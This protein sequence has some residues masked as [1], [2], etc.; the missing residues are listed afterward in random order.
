MPR[1]PGMAGNLQARQS[2]ARLL[3]VFGAHRRRV[4]FAGRA[5]GLQRQDH[6]D[7][8]AHQRGG[9]G[10]LPEAVRALLRESLDTVSEKTRP[11]RDERDKLANYQNRPPRVAARFWRRIEGRSVREWLR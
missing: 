11:T 1:R 8:P 7:Q 3:A 4:E 5:E 9:E 10:Y 6:H 2:A